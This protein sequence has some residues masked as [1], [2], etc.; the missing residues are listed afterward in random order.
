[1]DWLHEFAHVAEM[2]LGLLVVLFIL[3]Y[4]TCGIAAIFRSAVNHRHSRRHAPKE[5]HRLP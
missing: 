2:A 3:L 5:R 4:L 1:M